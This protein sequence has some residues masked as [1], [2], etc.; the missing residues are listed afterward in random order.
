VEELLKMLE[1]FGN[2]WEE[3]TIL[4]VWSFL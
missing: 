1:E 4:L 3:I 2:H